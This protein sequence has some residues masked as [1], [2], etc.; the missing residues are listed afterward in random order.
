MI[1]SSSSE[2]SE[3]E[4]GSSGSSDVREPLVADGSAIVE[5]WILTSQ[6]EGNDSAQWKVFVDFRSEET[7]E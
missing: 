5:R 2:S 1:W 7:Y 4:D 6:V 3:G